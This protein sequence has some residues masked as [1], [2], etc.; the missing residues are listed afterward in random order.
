MPHSEIDCVVYCGF[1]GK[2]HY[3]K[4]G[5]HREKQIIR[6]HRSHQKDQKPLLRRVQTVRLSRTLFVSLRGLRSEK[7]AY[8]VRGSDSVPYCV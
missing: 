1:T 7:S 5:L 6:Y 8:C 4:P 3:E 2:T